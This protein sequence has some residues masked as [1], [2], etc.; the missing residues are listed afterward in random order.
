M[1]DA[2]SNMNPH[3]EARLA[4]VWWDKEYGEQRGGSMDFWDSLSTR[5]K[6]MVVRALDE[7][8]SALAKNGRVK[9]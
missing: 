9:P 6:S 2:K 5:R 3:A 7:I 1:N 4:M 8:L